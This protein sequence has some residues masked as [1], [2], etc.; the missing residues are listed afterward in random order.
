MRNLAGLTHLRESKV[1]DL[2]DRWVVGRDKDIFRL[3]I[4]MSD[5]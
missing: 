3:K 1:G 5:S 4:S 2:D